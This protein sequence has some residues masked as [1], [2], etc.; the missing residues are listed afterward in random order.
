M[1]GID[2][3]LSLRLREMG[4]L[5]RSAGDIASVNGEPLIE[6]RHIQIAVKRSMTAEEQIK[7]RYGS[8]MQGLSSDISQSQREKSPYYFSNEQAK[9][10]DMFL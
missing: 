4:G 7:E 1:D 5:V 3:S 9:R 6:E 2:N 10:D 8:Y